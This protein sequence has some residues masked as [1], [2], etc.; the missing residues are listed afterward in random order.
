ML[1]VLSDAATEAGSRADPRAAARYLSASLAA[2]PVEVTVRVRLAGVLAQ[3]DPAGAIA[4]LNRALEL[5]TEPRQ[6][7]LIAVQ[8]G[9]TSVAAQCSPEAAEVLSRALEELGEVVGQ[10][11]TLDDQELRTLVE[12]ALIVTGFQERQ[13][14]TPTRERILAMSVPAGET[15]AERQKLAMMA[16]STA[17]RGVCLGEVVEQANRA[18]LLDDAGHGGWT[19][20]ASSIVLRLADD[21]EGAADAVDKVVV[22]SQEQASAWTYHVAIGARAYNH[23]AAGEVLEAAADAQ[24]SLDI[25]RQESW[26]HAT[27]LPRLVLARVLALQGK[28]S[29]AQL[30]L[31]QVSRPRF[32]DSAWEY[33]TYLEVQAQVRA[34]LGDDTG[35]LEALRACARSLEEAHFSNPA[36]VPWWVD[37][38]VLLGDAGRANEAEGAVEHGEDLAGRW[39]TARA[40]GLALFARG[41][42]TAGG[43]GIERL[44]EAAKVLRD[45]PARLELARAEHW[46][47]KALLDVDDTRAARLHLREAVNVATRGGAR[48][49][50][51]QAR[52]LLVAAGGRMRELPESRSDA[53]TGSERRV[54]EFALKGAS[55][56]EIASALFV[57]SRTVEVHLTN[58]YRKL[59]VIGRPE[60]ASGMVARKQWLG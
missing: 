46:L 59:D 56:R 40:R 36:F 9:M 11:P 14:V 15:M 52:D 8:F 39:D 49:L 37:L 5:V 13:T 31:A 45:S 24:M 57:T 3:I 26:E 22:R 21:L 41:V 33:P 23:L 1:D 48:F 29:E 28:M 38:A 54:V 42:I 34:Q 47:G 55:N 12:A 7:A 35:A 60:L 53:L 10:D 18:L 30:L 6:R 51:A 2:T 44:E 20:I 50:A 4:H 19:A 32:E 27:T 43:G 16:L 25:A 17:L 58:A